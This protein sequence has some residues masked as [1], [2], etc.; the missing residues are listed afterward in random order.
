MQLFLPTIY[1]AGA[2]VKIAD[3][4]GQTVLHY[5]ADRGNADVVKTL[6]E[7]GKY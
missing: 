7:A 2:D 3:N 1:F 5:A 4:D 6:L